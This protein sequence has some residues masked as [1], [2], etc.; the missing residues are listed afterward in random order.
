MDAQFLAQVMLLLTVVSL[1]VAAGV[2]GFGIG[3]WVFKLVAGARKREEERDVE[4]L[5]QALTDAQVR[6]ARGS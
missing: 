1:F 6:R 3:W 2:F 5:R 4:D